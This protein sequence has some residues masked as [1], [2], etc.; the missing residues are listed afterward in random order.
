MNEHRE[1]FHHDIDQ[2]MMNR[3]VWHL[4]SPKFRKDLVGTLMLAAFGIDEAIEFIDDLCD[5]I[6]EIAIQY[7]REAKKKTRPDHE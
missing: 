7:R 6:C 2:A 3:N 4:F 5:E 1:Q